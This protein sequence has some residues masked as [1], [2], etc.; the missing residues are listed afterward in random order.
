MGTQNIAGITKPRWRQKHE[1]INSSTNLELNLKT[2]NAKW[3]AA[4]QNGIIL[5]R[6]ILWVEELAPYA[7]MFRC[8]CWW[9]S[10]SPYSPAQWPQAALSWIVRFF[11]VLRLR[12]WGGKNQPRCF[13]HKLAIWIESGQVLL[14]H[15][16]S[17]FLMMRLYVDRASTCSTQLTQGADALPWLSKAE[18]N[19]NERFWNWYIYIYYAY[20]S[21]YKTIY[22]ILNYHNHILA[23]GT[24]KVQVATLNYDYDCTPSP[25][26]LDS[27]PKYDD[28]ERKGNVESKTRQGSTNLDP[29]GCFG[30]CRSP[31]PFPQLHVCQTLSH[32]IHFG[33]RACNQSCPFEKNRPLKSVA[34]SWTWMWMQIPLGPYASPLVHLLSEYQRPQEQR[35]TNFLSNHPLTIAWFFQC[36]FCSRAWIPTA[37]NKC[38]LWIQKWIGLS[39][40]SHSSRPSWSHSWN[41]PAVLWN[42]EDF[43]KAQGRSPGSAMFLRCGLRTWCPSCGPL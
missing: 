6:F 40:G 23:L 1:K 28:K 30:H 2:L 41:G 24:M 42:L 32:E 18:Q 37:E 22:I 12:H 31:R 33:T 38:T 20:V 8:F 19:E 29:D 15:P 27:L 13:Q 11:D 9:P 16:S 36:I 17:C 10:R 35:N 5:N 34:L 25:H 4:Q 39:R 43:P 21:L 7:C 14:Q 3:A 26:T